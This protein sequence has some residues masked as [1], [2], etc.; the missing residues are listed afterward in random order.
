MHHSTIPLF[1]RSIVEIGKL[2]FVRCYVKDGRYGVWEKR[3]ASAEHDNLVGIDLGTTISVIARLDQ[4]G[5]PTSIPNRRGDPLTPSVIYLDGTTAQVGETA[6]L[7]ARRDPGKAAMFIKREMG[8]P[9]YSRTVDG[10]QFRPETLSAIILRK[11]KQDAE[12]RIGP[13]SKAVIT[14][15]AFF[16]D[17]RRKATQDAGR[18]AGLD[19]LDIINEPTAAALSYAAFEAQRQGGNTGRILEIP[20]GKMTAVVYDL[21][22]GTF[23]VTVVELQSKRFETRATDGEVELGGKD[24]D[25]RIVGYL[26]EQFQQQYG[27]DPLADPQRLHALGALAEETKILLTD[28]DETPVELSHQGHTLAIRLSREQFEQLSSD[29]LTRSR[30]VTKLVVQN[31]A[32]L[33]WQAIDRVLLVGG[34]TRMPMVRRMLREL[35]GKEPDDSLDADQVVAQGAAIHAAILA[36]KA[37]DS[38]LAISD[39]LKRELR[40]VEP[41]AVNSH[42]LG[43]VAIRGDQR[44]NAVLVPKNTQLPAAASEVFATRRAGATSIRVKVLEGEAPEANHNIQI[45]QCCITG[46]PEG[47]PKGAPVQVRLAYDRNGRVSVMALDMIHGRFAQTEIERQNRLTDE[48]VRREAAFV[49]SLNIQ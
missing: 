7:A 49:D 39:D 9:L 4:S 43:V 13:I 37:D 25:D 30:V 22:G 5:V 42:S 34:S 29:L 19:V 44:L 24:W 40:E 48:D 23:D 36:A 18:I 16:D 32:K 1:H 2:F 6:K 10:R 20:G 47:L 3:M 46:L 26:A 31:Q 28:L 33:D 35:T 38:R 27:V 41:I 11:L 17:T 12:R 21:G 8:K 14:V 45:G 15:P